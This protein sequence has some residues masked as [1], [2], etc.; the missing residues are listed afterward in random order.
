MSKKIKEPLS[1]KIKKKWIKSK[2]TT[3]LLILILITA[4]MALNLLTRNIDLAQI[5]VT[6]NKVYSLT[7]KSICSPRFTCS[8][9]SSWP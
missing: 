6:E 2:P 3:I 4:F 1:L 5:D 8:S 9:R 7:E